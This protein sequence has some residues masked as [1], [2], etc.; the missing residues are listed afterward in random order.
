MSDAFENASLWSERERDQA[1][2]ID[3]LRA[4]LKT[5]GDDYPGSSFQQWCYEQAGISLSTSPKIGEVLQQIQAER[6]TE[7]VSGVKS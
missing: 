3:R 1:E 5:A 7:T 6:A 4:A 2:E